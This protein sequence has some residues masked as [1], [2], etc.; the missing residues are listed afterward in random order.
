MLGRLTQMT[1]PWDLR[2]ELR[3]PICRSLDWYRDG[4][5]IEEVDDERL[6]MRR[7]D[8]PAGEDLPVWSCNQC[9]HELPT[10]T[11]L[12]KTLTG[13]VRPSLARSRAS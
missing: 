1:E 8:E 6:V 5:L 13:L 4:L 11:A 2:V 9:S 3:C 10:W 12:S 7:V